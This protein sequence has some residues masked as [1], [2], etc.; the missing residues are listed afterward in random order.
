MPHVNSRLRVTIQIVGQGVSRHPVAGPARWVDRHSRR[1]PAAGPR[2]RPSTTPANSASHCCARSS[3]GAAAAEARSSA[4]CP[5]EARPEARKRVRLQDRGIKFSSRFYALYARRRMNL[6]SG[7]TGPA[8]TLHL[9]HRWEDQ[10]CRIGCEQSP[11]AIDGVHVACGGEARLKPPWGIRT[12]KSPASLRRINVHWCSARES[13]AGPQNA[14]G[15][16]RG[17]NQEPEPMLDVFMLVIGIGF[18]AAA[19]AY[20][21]VCDRL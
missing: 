19:V 14:A 8:P 10:Q 5:L 7:F 4:T 16:N 17:P 2:R 15:G 9:S 6:N 18:F 12:S 11:I 13:N 21:F 3:L 20:A 1:F